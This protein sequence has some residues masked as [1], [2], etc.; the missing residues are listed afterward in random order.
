MNYQGSNLRLPA[1]TEVVGA[2]RLATRSRVGAFSKGHLHC[3]QNVELALVS[4]S[5]TWRLANTY[6]NWMPYLPWVR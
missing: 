6:H 2:W 1:A 3:C 4:S 5:D